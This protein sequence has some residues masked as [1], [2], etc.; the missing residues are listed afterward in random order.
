[1]FAVV[2]KEIVEDFLEEPPEK[3]RQVLKEFLNVFPSKLPDTLPFM[4]DV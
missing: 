4:R 1:M 2:A 3:V